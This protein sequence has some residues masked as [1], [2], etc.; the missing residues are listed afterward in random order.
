MNRRDGSLQKLMQFLASGRYPPQSRLPP[1]REL[2]QMLGVSRSGLREGL[3]MLE[4]EERIWRHVGKGTFVGPRPLEAARGMDFVSAAT[5]PEEV[6]EVRM[7][8]EPLI[9]RQAAMRATS[10]EIENMW[11]LQEKS[12]GAR[13]VK[14]WELWDGTLHRAVAQ[15]A[16]NKLLLA[17]FDA[18]NAI[19]G[20]AAWVRLRQAAL[21]HERL[22]IYRQQHRAYVAAIAARDPALAEQAMR[23]HIRTVWSNL[24]GR[25]R[26]QSS[27]LDIGRDRTKRLTRDP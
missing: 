3:E 5:S 12:E 6:L 26:D 8:F 22:I 25:E 17:L 9:A 27:A 16:H 14:A 7:L 11:R 13:D 18:F 10:A 19:R 1:E 15:A 4:A 21:R 23:L 20:Q 2:A 24:L